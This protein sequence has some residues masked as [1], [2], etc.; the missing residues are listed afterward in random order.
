MIANDSLRSADGRAEAPTRRRL[1]HLAATVA[2]TEL[3]T[4]L[5]AGGAVQVSPGTPA[6]APR[7][8]QRAVLAPRFGGDA[9]VDWYSTAMR[10]LAGLGIT[11]KVG[12]QRA[13]GVL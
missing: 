13:T 1:L 2:A 11:T 5:T 8:I 4:V 7:R 3:L 9:T 12:F 6:A 10:Q